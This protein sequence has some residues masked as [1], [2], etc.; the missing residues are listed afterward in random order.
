MDRTALLGFS[1]AIS[2]AG[3]AGGPPLV[4]LENR[5]FYESDD[6][7]PG[8][9]GR[10]LFEQEYPPLNANVGH[11]GDYIGV[12]VLGG[13]VRLSRPVGWQVRRASLVP[14]KRFIE[15]VAPHGYLVAIYEREDS[16]ADPWREV[17]GR[18]EDDTKAKGAEILGRSIPIVLG[19]NQGREYVVRRVTKG[20]RAPYVNLSREILV[21][22][23]RRIDLVEI[24]HAGA[25]PALV[26][27][28]LLR[29]MDTLEVL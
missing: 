6:Q 24:V 17:L 14:E 22:S 10:A 11:V 16:P 5:T 23:D 29:V 20:Q 15:Y 21:R 26:S 3:C 19:E 18:Y 28:E 13:T 2:V 7:Q 12:T 4:A 1:L 9:S 8:A 25:T 27:G